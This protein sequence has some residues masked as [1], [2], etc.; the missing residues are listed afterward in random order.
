MYVYPNGP[1]RGDCELVYIYIHVPSYLVFVHEYVYNALT[2]PGFCNLFDLELKPN[3][4]IKWHFTDFN[5]RSLN[6][7]KLFLNMHA[8]NRVEY[9]RKWRMLQV[10]DWIC[11]ISG[12]VHNGH[13]RSSLCQTTVRSPE[14][15]GTAAGSFYVFCFDFCF[16]LFCFICFCLFV[17]LF[18]MQR[19]CGSRYRALQI[20]WSTYV[21]IAYQDN[22]CYN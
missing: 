5:I 3:F 12:T 9:N 4:L 22:V 15:G 7:G 14:G 1:S 13:C 11:T 20:E 19:S 6:R 10:M 18:W 16:V 8:I 21:V 2:S 17:C